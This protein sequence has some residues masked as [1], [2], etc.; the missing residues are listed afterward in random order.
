MLNFVYA[1]FMAPKNLKQLIK[2]KTL[3]HS[4]I[5]NYPLVNNNT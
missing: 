2:K 1:L 4:F 3:P 5:H